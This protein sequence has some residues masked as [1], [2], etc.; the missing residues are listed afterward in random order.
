MSAKT[1]SPGLIKHEI[2]SINAA[3]RLIGSRRHPLERSSLMREVSVQRCQTLRNFN[4]LCEHICKEIS[5]VTLPIVHV[6]SGGWSRRLSSD[7]FVMS[8]RVFPPLGSCLVTHSSAVA[9]TLIYLRVRSLHAA[10]ALHEYLRTHST[11]Q[12]QPLSSL[13][14]VHKS[15]RR[16][17]EKHEKQWLF[18]MQMMA[19]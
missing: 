13:A 2:E 6:Q 15:R 12:C 8:V 1:I 9:W 19:L 5:A 4:E 18:D 11:L 3:Q 10:S 14:K 17:S 7:C 16:K